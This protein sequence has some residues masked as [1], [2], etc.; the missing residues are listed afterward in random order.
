MF[1][2]IGDAIDWVGDKIFG[3][4]ESVGSAISE[5][6]WDIMLEWI[7]KTVFGAV[8]DFFGMINGMG[9]GIFNL[10]WVNAFLTLFLYFGW[11][12]FIAGPVVAVF[13]VAIE[14]QTGRANIQA[15]CINVLKGFMAVNLF[16]R[17]PVLLY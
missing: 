11:S 2:W 1:D 13:D 5:A 6:V 14:Y 16:T 10:G 12:L 4:V 3:A 17:V 8:S 15:T 7:Y 9:A